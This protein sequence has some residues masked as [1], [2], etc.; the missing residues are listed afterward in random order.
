MTG[1]P[2]PSLHVSIRYE[3]SA[4]TD[5]EA[6]QD[7]VAAMGHLAAEHPAAVLVDIVVTRVAERRYV[8]HIQAEEVS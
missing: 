8:W 2:E 1:A 6:W 5:A 4:P 7:L 3:D